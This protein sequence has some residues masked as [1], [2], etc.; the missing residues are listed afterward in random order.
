VAAITIIE[1]LQSK[2]HAEEA[3][4]DLGQEGFNG[5]KNSVFSPITPLQQD[6]EQL[7]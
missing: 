3:A 5:R 4:H 2:S 7:G 1:I 6:H